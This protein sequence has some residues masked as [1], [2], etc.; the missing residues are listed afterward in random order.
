MNNFHTKISHYQVIKYNPPLLGL[1]DS[2]LCAKGCAIVKIFITFI[3]RT[4]AV[5][6]KLYY[7]GQIDIYNPR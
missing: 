7:R 5:Y 2:H 3:R 4:E 1:L 6:M